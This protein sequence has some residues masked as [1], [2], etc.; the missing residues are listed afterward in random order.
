MNLFKSMRTMVGLEAASSTLPAAAAAPSVPSDR[1]A[2]MVPAVVQTGRL[3][4]MNDD[5]QA[6]PEFEQAVA[7]MRPKW[8]VV[9]A[10]APAIAL[11]LAAEAPFQ[12]VVCNSAAH[13]SNWIDFLVDYARQFPDSIRFLRCPAHDPPSNRLNS[14]GTRRL[15]SELDAE[16][17]AEALT[18]TFRLHQWM[19]VEGNRNLLPRMKR[20]P[21]L[22]AVYNQVLAELAK[23]EASVQFVGR[24]ISKEPALTAKI[25][26]WVNAAGVG[27]QRHVDDPVEAVLHLGAERTKSLILAA[28]VFLQ[29]DKTVCAGFS[30]EKLWQHSMAV[31]GFARSLMN[32]QAQDSRLSELAFTAGLLHDTGKLL[33]A[34][35][36]ADEYSR[37]ID[38]AARRQVPERLVEREVF[39]TTHAEVGA[40][41][42]GTWGLPLQILEAIAWHHRPLDAG[43]CQFT[44]LS[45]VHV[46]EA[47]D[48]EKRAAPA[49]ALLNQID[50][51]YVQSI[52][53]NGSQNSW[54]KECG[55]SPKYG[56]SEKH[57]LQQEARG[58]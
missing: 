38:Q 35:N 8:E 28:S 2:A 6:L 32:F 30:H 31:G 47:I 19:N 4:C 51:E 55:C 50:S 40:C 34:A 49:D 27:L 45:A 37:I 25:L 26:Q 17:V 18:R 52:G 9:F 21:S 5:A 57:R 42:L 13:G 33:L 3:L 41:F 15:M 24:L 11:Q 20:L 43:D 29:F 54:R 22:P 46:A 10:S 23:P 58:I 7:Q 14:A 44:L 56:N 39:G 53:L 12:L 1:A 48:N 36:L 16:R